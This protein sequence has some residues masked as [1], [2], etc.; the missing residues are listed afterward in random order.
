MMNPLA[1]IVALYMIVGLVWMTIDLMR[2]SDSF[3]RLTKFKPHWS[4][5]IVIIILTAANWW[6]NIEKGL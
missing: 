5:I 3:E 4:F 6:W 2:N 1:V